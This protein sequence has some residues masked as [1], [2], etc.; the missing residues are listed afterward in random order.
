MK[1]LLTQARQLMVPVSDFREEGSPLTRPR[2]QRATP[3]SNMLAKSLL[4]QKGWSISGRPSF[5]SAQPLQSR[6][7]NATAT[8][9]ATATKGPVSNAP[10]HHTLLAPAC[11]SPASSAPTCEGYSLFRRPCL[12]APV[13]RDELWGHPRRHDTI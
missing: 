10:S 11:F 13:K 6:R 8:V 2:R 12:R 4:W 9:T 5:F 3:N 7:T 1:N